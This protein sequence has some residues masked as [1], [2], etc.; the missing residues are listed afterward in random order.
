MPVGCRGGEVAELPLPFPSQLRGLPE[1][2][3]VR[4]ASLHQQQPAPAAGL[5]HALGTGGV[6]MDGST[7][8]PPS[9]G[10]GWFLC[11]VSNH[12]I[13]LPGNA[14]GSIPLP[15]GWVWAACGSGELWAGVP[16]GAP[17]GW[18]G[19]ERSHCPV[20]AAFLAEHGGAGEM[21][22]VSSH[23]IISLPGRWGR[24][25][26]S[27]GTAA[28]WRWQGQGQLLL[29]RVL[30]KL[31]PGE[32]RARGEG[33]GPP[34]PRPPASAASANFFKLGLASPPPHLHLPVLQRG[35]PCNRCHLLGRNGTWHGDILTLPRA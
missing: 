25:R 23:F 24:A 9:E 20:P 8:F 35:G 5:S 13:V 12:V 15:G 33:L 34:Y 16:G 32:E 6:G 11:A 30:L 17:L 22:V 4:W 10:W 26:L 27:L 31:A 29:Q 14:D 18:L 28:R 2:R 19:W 21:L 1:T 3:Q 7:S